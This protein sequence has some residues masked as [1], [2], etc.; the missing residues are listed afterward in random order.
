MALL[1]CGRR[2]GSGGVKVG[3]ELDALDATF[4]GTAT[5]RITSATPASCHG[6]LNPL[7]T[8]TTL[9]PALHM[10]AVQVS[11]TLSVTARIK[12]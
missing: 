1:S 4:G 8:T 5:H 11:C 3:G 9:P 12:L 2:R 6:P 7:A 10:P